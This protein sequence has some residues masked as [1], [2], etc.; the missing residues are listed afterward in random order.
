MA[1]TL[2]FSRREDYANG[3]TTLSKLQ[4]LQDKIHP[5]FTRFKA[6]IST[7]ATLKEVNAIFYEKAYYSADKFTD[8]SNEL[9]SYETKFQGYLTS[10]E[11]LRSR[12]QDILNMVYSMINPVEMTVS[13]NSFC[14]SSQ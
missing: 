6:S 7:I 2:N 14:S 1:L 3:L 13:A 4:H 9:S 11:L 10:V 8:L 5:L 12:S